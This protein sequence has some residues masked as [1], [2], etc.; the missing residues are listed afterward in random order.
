MSRE[1]RKKIATENMD[2]L[3]LGFYTLNDKKIEL[4]IPKSRR[5][6]VE[7]YTP[8]LLANL[9]VGNQMMYDSTNVIVND[10]NSFDAAWQ[11]KESQVV[12]ICV[13]LMHK[14]RYFA[15]RVVYISPLV[16]ARP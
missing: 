3:R 1:S 11:M 9:H 4:T 2:V 13:E 12:D 6:A 14:K 5:Q 10:L 7:V 15:V 16:A 8:D